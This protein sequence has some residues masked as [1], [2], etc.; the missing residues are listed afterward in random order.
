MG[1]LALARTLAC[2]GDPPAID[3][4]AGSSGADSGAG[5]HPPVVIDADIN[6]DRVSGSLTQSGDTF[7]RN[8]TGDIN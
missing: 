4:D 8:V 7:A 6:T 1:A 2:S 3:A 5:A